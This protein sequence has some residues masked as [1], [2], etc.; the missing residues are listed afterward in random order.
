[1]HQLQWC[2]LQHRDDSLC[3]P[4]TDLWSAFLDYLVPLVLWSCAKHRPN[5]L[6]QVSG[7]SFSQCHIQEEPENVIP[8]D[9]KGN[10]TRATPTSSLLALKEIIP[11]SCPSHL[12]TCCSC[13]RALCFGDMDMKG[14]VQHA[15]R[16]RGTRKA[17]WKKKQQNKKTHHTHQKKPHKP[18]T[19]PHQS[20]PRPCFCE[21]LC[22][23]KVAAKPF[24]Q[25]ALSLKR[26][27]T[28]CCLLFVG[29]WHYFFSTAEWHWFLKNELKKWENCKYLSEHKWLCLPEREHVYLKN[30]H[31]CTGILREHTFTKAVEFPQQLMSECEQ[32]TG[33]QWG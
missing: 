32:L 22:Y 30:N 9:I 8:I 26:S 7:E 33:L 1:M 31:S 24:E 14:R 11:F 18:R 17:G 2:R 3:Y 28:V 6:I 5:K 19:T 4:L 20:S 12:S 10:R 29:G 21:D 27:Q 15:G 23:L 13:A 16:L 25:T